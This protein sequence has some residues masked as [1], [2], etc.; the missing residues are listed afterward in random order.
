MTSRERVRNAFEHRN[1]DCVPVDFGGMCCSMINAKIIADLRDYFS[2]PKSLPRINDMS[3]MTAYVDDDL[4]ECLG[5]DIRQL[6]NFSDTYGHK[7]TSWKKWRYLGQE[8]L[9]PASCFPQDDGHGGWYVFPQGDTKCSPSGHMPA[10]GYYFDNLS[11]PNMF[12]EEN[13]NPLDNVEDYSLVS[14]EQI[15][16]HK[17]L[18]KQVKDQKKAVQVGPAYM[19]L[20]D[21]NN[22]PGPSL[23]KPRGIRD[24][25]E[26]YMAPLLYPD[27]VNEVFER[28][29]VKTIE[30]L[31]LYW[32]EFGEEIDIIYICGTDFGTQNG[33][34]ISPDLFSKM[35]LP[36]YRKINDW[37]H[38]NTT[39][40][41]LKHCCGGIYEIMP[42]I[43]ESGFDALNPVQ[44]T[45]K[46]MNPQKLKQEFGCDIVFWGGG[47]DTQ[48]ILPFGSPQDV[49]RQVL[50][51]LEIFSAG[52]G[53]IFGTV[54]NIQA[55]TPIANIVSMIN[56]VNE[57]NGRNVHI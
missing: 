44:C 22:V 45:A 30:N 41:T 54:H 2:L 15:L 34:M 25:A 13:P 21:A 50:E 4:A 42:L 1:P 17:A 38:A 20:G 43:I 8:I 31:K 51:R 32:E 11:H 5:C 36:Y 33:P 23:K 40:K 9:I 19:G 6:N 10:N 18:L 47:I 53:Y 16:F 55:N 3:T 27:Y 35:Y 57:F 14:R 28:G 56:A 49:R 48:T 37:V 12:D 46:G 7:T 39:W 26:W 52:G 24:I 29:T